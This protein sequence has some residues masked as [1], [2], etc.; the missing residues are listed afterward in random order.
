MQEL[1]EAM[2]TLI[3]SLKCEEI[4][5]LTEQARNHIGCT[6]LKSLFP[7][8]RME[9]MLYFLKGFKDQYQSSSTPPF[10]HNT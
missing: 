9:R 2:W 8:T 5:E 3:D 4:V 6:H 10:I 1:R 7:L